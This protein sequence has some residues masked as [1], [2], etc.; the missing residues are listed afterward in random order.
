MLASKS[1]LY[2]RGNTVNN[3]APTMT[4]RGRIGRHLS[5]NIVGY[6]ALLIAV[7]MTPLPSWAAA[8]I[9][10]A[11]IKNGAVTTSK[12]KANA[13]KSSKIN[14]GT[15]R[16]ADLAPA[17]KGFTTIVT[18]SASTADVGAGASHQATVTC[19]AGQVAIGGGGYSSLGGIII[20]GSTGG[21]VT[22]SHPTN[23]F[24]L[25]GFPFTGASGNG[26]APTGWR[27]TV[28][29]TEGTAQTVTH[30]AICASK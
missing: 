17:A 25:G 6:V 20:I 21:E 5:H 16:K 23:S 18:K 29:N 28:R 27:T 15:I 30:Y 8:T 12:L 9:G 24:N 19:D 22:K 13:V 10:T 26:V 11:D 7:S 1:V 4:R 2:T 14:D 3:D